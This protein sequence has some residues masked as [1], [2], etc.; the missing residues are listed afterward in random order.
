M[1]DTR[2]RLRLSDLVFI[3][4]L[5]ILLHLLWQ[6]RAPSAEAQSVFYSAPALP[7]DQSI[8]PPG[9]PAG[10]VSHW[11]APAEPD[12]L[13]LSYFTVPLPEISLDDP[14]PLDL[15][16]PPTVVI[17]TL[18][19]IILT[20]TCTRDNYYKDGHRYYHGKTHCTEPVPPE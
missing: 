11:V 18:P 15:P 2:F 19:P 9:L 20:R 6:Y 17:Q 8:E 12:P 5:A 16:P 3:A 7:L 10:E 13:L 1:G 4:T 14:E